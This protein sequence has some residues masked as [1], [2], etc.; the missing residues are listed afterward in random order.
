MKTQVVI[1][2]KIYTG[3]EVI[4]SGFIRYVKT[5]TEIGLMA[6]Y[7]PQEDEVVFDAEGKI[8]I[9]GMIDVHIHGGYDIDAMDANSDGLVTLGQ[10]MLKE[11]VTTY[12]PTTMTQAPEA[13]ERALR[14]AKEAKEKGAHFEYI[15]LEGPYVSKK[16]AGAQ[17]L[18]H[19]VP[20]NIEQFKKW[21]EASGNLI[22]L[23]TYA[24]EEEG[25][26]E[27]EEYLAETGV[28]GTIGHTDAIDEQL[29]NRKIT[30]ATH[31]YNQ[32]RGLHHREPGVVGHVLLNPEIMVE[33]ITDGIHIHPDMV[34]LAYK[35]KGPKKISVI[36][37]AMRAKGLEDGLYELGGQPVHVKDGSA[38]LE[39]GTLAGSILKMDQAFRNVIQFTGCSIEDAVLMT[40]VN[41][42]EEFGLTNKGALAVG[43]DADFVV[44]NEDLHV[45]DTVRLG[46]HMKKGKE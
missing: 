43:K 2:A 45:Y 6:Q 33:I 3:Q 26:I 14:A 21:Q 28:V 1:N 10:E 13:I 35:L 15:H 40:S 44:M 42:A 12:F 9:P 32:M 39:D 20:A 46:I 37:D 38:R 31:L 4:E 17:P 34:K 11:G 19:I 16:R 36:T 41:Q 24:P 23:V 8:I 22:K 30:H 29:K 25:A 18:E 7:V 27:F 5:I